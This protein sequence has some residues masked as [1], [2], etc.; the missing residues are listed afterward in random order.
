MARKICDGHAHY[1]INSMIGSFGRFV[2]Y[3]TYSYG[4]LIDDLNKYNIEKIVLF[5]Q[6]DPFSLKKD[7]TH[8]AVIGGFLGGVHELAKIDPIYVTMVAGPLSALFAGKFIYESKTGKSLFPPSS[9]REANQNIANIEDNRVEFVPFV[10][11]NFKPS[12]LEGFE[13]IKGVKYY[14]TYGGIPDNLLSYL[15]ENELN[16]VLHPSLRSLSK[17]EKFLKKVEA[18]DGINFQIAHLA[19]GNSGFI[20]ALGKYENLYID[21][22]G[23]TFPTNRLYRFLHKVVP[24]EKIAQDYP[25]R[26]IYGSDRPW[27]TQESE[28]N[29]VN[30]LDI[31]ER[32][33]DA[34]LY[35]N[36]LK[37][38]G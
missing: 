38:W 1:G 30:S 14:A 36:C 11:R 18:N 12:D 21:T 27:C 28:L 19:Y 5:A 17:P 25:D 6:P 15:N 8:L 35:R 9:Y 34:I 29:V 2:P 13:N 3:S 24:I 7:I 20:N 37:L 33:K 10:N 26:V 4:E 22:S 31:S 16:L 32:D 23:Y